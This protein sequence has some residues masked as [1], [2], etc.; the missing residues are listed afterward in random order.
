MMNKNRI[1]TTYPDDVY[2]EIHKEAE[3]LQVE[4]TKIIKRIVVDHYKKQA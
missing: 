1:N 4:P 3:K 2:E